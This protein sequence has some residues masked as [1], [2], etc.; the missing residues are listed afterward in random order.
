[1]DAQP[2]YPF[3]FSFP[4]CIA[5]KHFFLPYFAK[6]MLLPK[7]VYLLLVLLLF[8]S[9]S[10]SLTYDL[11]NGCYSLLSFSFLFFLYISLPFLSLYFSFPPFTTSP[12][13]ATSYCF[14]LCFAPSILITILGTNLIL[15]RRKQTLDHPKSL[16]KDPQESLTSK[17]NWLQRHIGP[18][19]TRRSI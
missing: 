17:A 4:P 11:L 7:P 8:L 5:L 3:S 10:C 19:C 14:S 2:Y 13:T 18:V 12:L 16:F 9:S 6:W 15:C 1:M